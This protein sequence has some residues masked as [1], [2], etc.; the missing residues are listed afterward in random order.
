MLSTE[1]DCFKESGW[2][3][4][5]YLPDL[6]L[7][8][9]VSKV[10][11]FRFRP[12]IFLSLSGIYNSIFPLVRYFISHITDG[13]ANSRQCSKSKYTQHSFRHNLSL[14]IGF[15]SDNIFC[16]IICTIQHVAPEASLGIFR[17]KKRAAISI[18]T[19]RSPL[20][21]RFLTKAAFPWQ[22]APPWKPALCE[23]SRTGCKVCVH[24]FTLS[25]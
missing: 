12:R 1:K 20:K 14:L 18:T 22:I 17:N 2:F 3:S 7:S 23:K 6:S 4:A 21:L 11:F 9:A 5:I 13:T 8:V 15:L 10:L 25:M 24:T 19:N 16:S